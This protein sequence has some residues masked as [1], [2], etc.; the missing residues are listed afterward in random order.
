MWIKVDTNKAPHIYVG[1]LRNSAQ[2]FVPEPGEASFVQKEQHQIKQFQM[3]VDLSK[4]LKY[5]VNST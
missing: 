4:L 2:Q 1:L 5:L 3:I